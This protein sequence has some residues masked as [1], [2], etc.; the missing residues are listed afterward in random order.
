MSNVLHIKVG[1]PIEGSLTRARDI[2]EALERGQTPEPYFGIGFAELPQLL[3]V[4][5]SRR[6]ELLRLLSQDGPMTIAELA[7]ALRR[8]YKNV[9]GDVVALSE[10]LAVERDEDGR[11]FVPWDEID[12]RLPLQHKT[13]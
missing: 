5:T 9:H 3:A 2:M 8:D 7:R 13:A 11:V 1:E 4:F 6:W 12:L 10:W